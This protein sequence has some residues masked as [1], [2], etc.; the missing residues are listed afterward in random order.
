MIDFATVAL[1]Q[2]VNVAGKGSTCYLEH[3][4]YNIVS[5]GVMIPH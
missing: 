5:A 2:L 4:D 1:E 3:G